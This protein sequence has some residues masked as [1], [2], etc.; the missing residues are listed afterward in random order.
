MD[1][2]FADPSTIDKKAL[3]RLSAR[4]DG[5]GLVQLGLHLLALGATA[6]LLGLA[7]GGPWTLPALLAHGIVL[8][9]LFAPLHECIHRTA[10]KTRVLND[11]LAWVCGALIVLP[12]AYFRAFHFAHHRFTQ[13]TERDPELQRVMPSSWPSYLWVVSG[14]PYWRERITTSLTHALTGRVDAPFVPRQQAAGIVLEARILWLV[15]GAVAAL[16]VASG[17]LV[18]VIYWILP[19]LA[20]Q[21]FLRMYLLA[22]HGGCPHVPDMLRNSRTT[23]SNAAVRAL[24]W[25]MPYHTAHHAFPAVPFHALPAAHA[26]IKNSVAVRSDSYIGYQRE[27]IAGFGR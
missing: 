23:H 3:K 11:I 5:K 24:A 13:D 10:F 12:P 7:W 18:A 15:Y 2:A 25:N 8:I 16:S 4:S 26:V 20:G 21:P 27:L 17:S 19:A 9:F 22:E 14:L 6:T 1:E